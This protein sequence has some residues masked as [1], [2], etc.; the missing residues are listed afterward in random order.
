MLQVV[1]RRRFAAYLLRAGRLHRLTRDH[2]YV[3]MLVDSGMMSEE[4]AAKSKAR[5]MLV[6]AVGGSTKRS[7]STSS[8]F[9]G[10]RRPC[11]AVQRWADRWRG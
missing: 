11:V 5:H 9:A 7:T 6:N 10:Q 2:T 3:Q 1:T 4:E 8:G